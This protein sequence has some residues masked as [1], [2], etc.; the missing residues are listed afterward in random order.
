VRDGDPS[1][2]GVFAAG[3]RCRGGWCDL[4]TVDLRSGAVTMLARG[5]P[6]E[7]Y[8]RPRVSPDGSRLAVAVHT[9]G[10]WRVQIVSVRDGTR[11]DLAA[12]ANAYDVSWASPSS[13]VLVS[14]EG[15]IAN[16][17]RVD[18][19]SGVSSPLTHA[20]RGAG[21]EPFRRERVVSLAL[22]ERV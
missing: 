3:A 15:G 8:Y 5:G 20:T 18:L 2:D 22:L 9:T 19:A 13:I 7:S 6:R 12:T 10:G 14:E 21:D 1:P 17:Q 11:V 16:I 4:V